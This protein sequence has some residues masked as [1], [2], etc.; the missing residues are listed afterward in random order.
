M[1][2]KYFNT[3]KEIF[4]LFSIGWNGS[5]IPPKWSGVLFLINSATKPVVRSVCSIAFL[6]FV[7][8]NLGSAYLILFVFELP[9][10]SLAKQYVQLNAQPAYVSSRNG[11]PQK[12][13]WL[14]SPSGV[15]Y[16]LLLSFIF[17][18]FCVLL[19]LSHIEWRTTSDCEKTLSIRPQKYL[20]Y[21]VVKQVKMFIF[22]A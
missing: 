8:I 10:L 20:K 1:E 6:N 5:L 4:S 22:I 17:L 16:S 3:F 15:L 9:P 18:L 14:V 7:I 19:A 11:K 12:L 21:L 13:N 2:H